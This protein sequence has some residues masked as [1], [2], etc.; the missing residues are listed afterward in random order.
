M[1]RKYQI[2]EEQEKLLRRNYDEV[3]KDMSEMEVACIGRINSLKE[4]KRNASYQLK[5]L[6]EQLKVAYPEVEY[7][8]RL[9]ELEI[10]RQENGDMIARLAEQEVKV[11]DLQ[12]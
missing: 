7:D 11:S 10:A 8:N 5:S 3:Y 4:W 9:K 6:Y 1:T 12:S 2:L